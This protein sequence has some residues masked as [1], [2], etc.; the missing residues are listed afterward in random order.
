MDGEGCFLISVCKNI[1]S[2]SG[3]YVEAIF[4]LNLHKKDK[5]LLE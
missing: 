4:Q 3:R 2:K 5:A 1:K